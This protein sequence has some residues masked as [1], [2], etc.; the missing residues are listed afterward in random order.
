MAKKKKSNEEILG[1]MDYPLLLLL[2][3]L[4]GLGL[5]LMFSSSF[6][7]ALYQ[8][9]DSTY[10]VSQQIKFILFG[11]VVMFFLSKIN[12]KRYKSLAWPGFWL[13]ILLLILVLFYHTD[14]RDQTRWIPIVGSFTLQPSEV[15]KFALILLF[16]YM[17]SEAGPKYMKTF[18]YGFV[19]F[20]LPLGG[21]LVLLL[22][23]P[24]LSGVILLAGIGLLMMAVGG[25]RWIYLGGSIALG[26]AALVLVVKS[27]IKASYASAR[28][29]VWR[30]PGSDPADTGYQTLQSLMAVAS[31]GL[32]G[33]G[34]GNSR[35]KYLYV[36]EPQNDFIFAI[37]SEE[38]GFV[39][40]VAIILLF[41]LFVFRG[42]YIA[43]RVKDPFGKMLMVGV[44]VQIGLQALLNVAVVTNTIP[45]T[46]I[47]LP[48][49]SYGGT[50]MVMLLAEIGV[51][52]NVSRYQ[53]ITPLTEDDDDDEEE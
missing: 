3:A 25:T 34:I 32:F 38:L 30:N 15:A 8:R 36:P 27:G 20:A 10:Y 7:T 1:H 43:M 4:L 42:L 45:N 49:F 51:V 2:F 35:Q 18:H 33:Q 13:S 40:A 5:I 47:S 14:N 44:S 11:L 50:S 29:A 39:G 28:I 37:I 16:A 17:I 53:S 52:L 46:G 26:M 31:G 48:F 23:E 21:I 12:Y 24:H 22:L 41:I 6:V 19:N 9:D